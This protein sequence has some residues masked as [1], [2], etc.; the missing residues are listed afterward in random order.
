FRPFAAE[1][2]VE[3]LPASVKAIA[4]LDRT[5]EPGSLGEPL[6]EDVR[7]ALG[8]VMSMDKSKF[9]SYPKVV[10]GRYGL[11]SAE[12]TPGMAKAVLDNLKNQ[13]PK[14]HFTIGINDDVAFTSLDWDNS[15]SLESEKVHRALFYGLGSD[16][17]VGANHNSIRIIG[18]ATD[19]YAQG[20]FVYDSKKAGTMTTSLL[21]FGKQKIKST[22]LIHKANFLACHKFSFLEKY[23]ILDNLEQGGTFLLAAPFDKAHVWE[24]LPKR[25][26]QHIIGKK[27]KFYVIDALSVAEKLGLGGRINTIMQ[28]AFFKISGIIPEEE[29]LKLINESI[30]HSY[31]KKG[32]EIVERN[33]KAVEAAAA[34]LEKVDY[35]ASAA[36]TQ[37]MMPSVPGTAPA[38]VKDVLGE[39][40][41]GRGTELPVSKMPDDGTFPT[42]TTKY[43]KRNIAEYIP[44]WDPETCIQCG[45]CS[46]VCPHAVIRLKAYKPE[47]LKNAP[48]SFKSTGAKGKEFEGLKFTI[49]VAPE[50]CTGCATCVHVCPAFKKNEAGEKTDR[51]AINMEEQ[52][53]LRDQEVINWE[54]FLTLPQVDR[55]LLKLTTTKGT[56]FLEPLFEFSGACAGCGETPYVKL[57]SQLF[58]DR[59]IIANATGCSSIYGGNLPTTPYTA[60]ADGRGP[61]WSNSLFEDAAEFG[62]GMRLTSDKLS[63]Y[64]GEL[65]QRLIESKKC[66]VDTALLENIKANGQKTW[67]DIEKQRGLTD[68]LKKSIAACSCGEC[69]ELLSLTDH[70][71]RRAVWVLGG[72]GWA[73]DIGYGGLDHVLATGRNVNVLVLDTEVYSNTGG[74]MSKATPVGAIAKFAAGGKSL[75]KKDLGL[76]CMSYGYVYVARIALGFNRTQTIKAFLEAESYNGPSIIIAYSHCINQGINMTRGLDQ[77]KAAVTSGMWP[78]YRYN[79]ELTA[80]GKNPLVMD[81]KEPTTEVA[82][83]IYKETRFKSLKE[84]NPARAETLLAQ[85]KKDVDMQYK[86]YKYL[87]ERPF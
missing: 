30:V 74:Q 24:Q 42:G 49:Q 17:T 50:D 36:S 79:P 48:A 68:Q 65:V 66:S 44:V 16:G 67:E 11:G 57:L 64:A 60:R 9:S 59:A 4:V 38:F 21:R 73:Y 71:I 51:K 29:A 82:D 37:E 43:E 83:Y 84:M 5:K 26:Q 87:A 31:G 34:H 27:L 18:E 19:N 35:P 41:A 8:E 6:Y 14:N 62:L 22:Y 72:D 39:I 47:L 70:L 2:M 61:A 75:R 10:G 54:F 20:Y 7:T 1:K 69:S 28:T 56:Q 77:Q 76:M 63:E 40:I 45:D 78:L 46:A 13:S 52:I 55:S 23:D 12:F 33:M 25:V 85:L 32:K 58:G 86:Q 3:A 81:S 80:E 15:W 53:P